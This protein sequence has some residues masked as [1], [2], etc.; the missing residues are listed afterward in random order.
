MSTNIYSNNYRQNLI[1]HMQQFDPSW[2]IPEGYHVHHIKPKSLGGTHAPNN[3]IALH[4]DDHISIHKC[5]GDKISDKFINCSQNLSGKNNPFYGKKH[6]T[7]TRK[8]MSESW[9]NISDQSRL[10]MSI[11]AKQRKH[12]LQYIENARNAQLGKK[13]SSKTKALMS[14]QRLGR[15]WVYNDKLKITKFIYPDEL[16]NLNGFSKGRRYYN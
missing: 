6:S 7:K 5:R 15:I 9:K 14:S 3:L 16:K 4:V 12:N 1:N 11:A 13:A 8:Q 10:N 2:S